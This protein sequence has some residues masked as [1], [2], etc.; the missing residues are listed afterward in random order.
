MFGQGV[1]KHISDSTQI[2]QGSY[3]ILDTL[4]SKF[5]TQNFE[6]CESYS[7]FRESS[8]KF[9]KFIKIRFFFITLDRIEIL[10]YNF[11]HMCM[12]P[13]LTFGINF[14]TVRTVVLR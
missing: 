4:K 10:G 8:S 2:F 11:Y 14:M 13:R 5:L 6:F 3:L 1:L 7:D 9:L 12:G